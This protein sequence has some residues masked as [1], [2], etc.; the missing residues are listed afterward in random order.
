MFIVVSDSD[1]F[2]LSFALLDQTRFNSNG[3]GYALEDIS[4]IGA[5]L[6]YLNARSQ[7]RGIKT[8]R[9]IMKDNQ[10]YKITL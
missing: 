5:K 7:E 3:R 2:V 6:K 8:F 10:I 9:V 4:L 1:E